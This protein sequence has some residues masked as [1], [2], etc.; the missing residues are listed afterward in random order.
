MLVSSERF[1][2]QTNSH[3]IEEPKHPVPKQAGDSCVMIIPV[4][5]GFK[6][7][8]CTTTPCEKSIKMP[9]HIANEMAVKMNRDFLK[10]R[11]HCPK[12][13]VV[14]YSP[15]GFHVASVQVP[16]DWTAANEYS[17]PPV[18]I[19]NLINSDARRVVCDLNKSMM[20]PD[21]EIKQWAVHVK[22]LQTIEDEKR[23]MERL[24]V[25]NLRPCEYEFALP[26]SESEA[27]T[28]RVNSDGIG[29]NEGTREDCKRYLEQFLNSLGH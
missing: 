20:E 17:M 4:Q 12:W 18:H 7:G 28:F 14:V 24:E 10:N 15:S 26:N 11:P 9:R 23:P 3:P 21:C 25:Q 16:H 1:V 29:P 19:S 2:S 5:P 6:P 22:P 8:G 27:I 13:C